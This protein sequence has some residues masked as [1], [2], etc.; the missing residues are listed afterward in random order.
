MSNESNEEK[1][2]TIVFDRNGL[3]NKKELVGF[4]DFDNQK[5]NYKVNYNPNIERELKLL[6]S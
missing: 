3:L 1:Q 4:Y 5:N 2:S 6:Q